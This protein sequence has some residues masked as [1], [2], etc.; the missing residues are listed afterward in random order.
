MTATSRLKTRPPAAKVLR[1]QFPQPSV[2]KRIEAC[3][4]ANL[5]KV[6]SSEQLREVAKHP[7][8]K[9]VENWHQRLSELRT[10]AGYTILSERDCPGVLAPGEYVMPDAKKRAGAAKRVLPTA[11]TWQQVLAQAGH[12]CAWT[13][14]AVRCTLREG[15]VDAVGGGTVR[16]TADHH[17]PHSVNPHA[18]PKDP[19][20]WRPLC[21]RH[22]VMKKNY[23][24]S[25]TGKVNL[26]AILQA[27]SRSEKKKALNFLAEVLGADVTFPSHG[28][29]QQ[30]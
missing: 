10:D 4:L 27:A 20:K 26:T 24:D 7:D 12:A 8:G 17:S 15:D 2:R 6:I 19:L 5:G 14:D 13:E 29:A 9:A 23:W 28:D 25:S 22:Q 11:A 1:S 30:P 21:G 18:D 3:F 16:L